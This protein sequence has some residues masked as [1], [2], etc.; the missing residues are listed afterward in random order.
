MKPHVVFWLR[1]GVEH[2]A[3]G[4]WLDAIAHPDVAG[5]PFQPDVD[6]VLAQNPGGCLVVHEHDPA[7][8]DGWS[9][10]EKALGLDRKFRAVSLTERPYS[11]DLVANLRSLPVIERVEPDL[12]ASAAVP[13]ASSM[14]AQPSD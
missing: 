8:T 10:D 13:L 12:L 9:A 2:R 7:R 14:N 11:V 6:K 3:V 5:P 1:P 4:S